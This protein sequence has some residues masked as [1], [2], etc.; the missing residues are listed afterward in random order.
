MWPRSRVSS[1]E[2]IALALV[3]SSGV[4]PTED[5]F[6]VNSVNTFIKFIP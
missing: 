3:K 5:H 2:M 6:Y 1:L 4:L